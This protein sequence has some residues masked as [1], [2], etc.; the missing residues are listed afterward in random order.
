MITIIVGV[1]LGLVL[2]VMGL[3]TILVGIMMIGY[4]IRHLNKNDPDF[5]GWFVG[6]VVFLIFLPVGVLHIYCGAVF[7]IVEGWGYIQ[8]AFKM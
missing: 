2:I 3:V 6:I 1:F 5:S 4:G 7:F 8:L